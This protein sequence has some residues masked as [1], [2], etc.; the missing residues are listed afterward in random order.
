MSAKLASP[1][2]LYS[3]ASWW[4]SDSEMPTAKGMTTST[5]SP[6]AAGAT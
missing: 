5:A 4:K 1:T 2:K 6:A 3:P